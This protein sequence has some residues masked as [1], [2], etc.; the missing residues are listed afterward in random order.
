[1]KSLITKGTGVLALLTL[2]FGIANFSGCASR[3][4]EDEIID[5]KSFLAAQ[6][7]CK[8]TSRGGS[9]VQCVVNHF[10]RKAE[11]YC[12]SK[13]LSA[14]SKQCAEIKQKVKLKAGKFYAENLADA[15]DGK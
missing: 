1:M 11:L 2:G 15:I 14:P 10:E 9:A 3:P 7:E 13:E 5:K 8:A 4:P 12:A 6:A